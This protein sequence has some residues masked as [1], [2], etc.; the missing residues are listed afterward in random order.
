[1]A[2]V[3]LCHA[4]EDKNIVR[5]LAEELTKRGVDVWYDEY[6]L[7][8]GDSLISKI[9]DGLAKSR[10]GVVI[11]SKNFF[12]KAWPE[13]ELRGLATRE[14]SEGKKV[15]LPIWHG[16]TIQDILDVHP[17]LA[18]K[19]GIDTSKGLHALVDAILSTLGER[20]DVFVNLPEINLDIGR[21]PVTNY[22]Y[23]RFINDGGYHS[24]GRK[25]WWSKDGLEVWEKYISRKNHQY[26][27]E[28]Q[29][30]EDIPFEY[31]MYW[32][33]SRYNKRSQPVVGVSWFE[34]EAY[35]NWLSE[36]LLIKKSQNVHV[37]LP[38]EEEWRFAAIGNKDVIFPWGNAPPTNL[39][40]HL[41]YKQGK[42]STLGEY[43]AGVSQAGCHDLIGNVWEWV[44]DFSPESSEKN[45]PDLLS[46][47]KIMGGCVF[48]LPE[49]I[50]KIPLAYRRPGYR[51]AVIG[52]RTVRDFEK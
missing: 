38:T 35:C 5:P 6:S 31:P 9:D 13:R 44:H 41:G 39:C 37:R 43:T 51:H 49:T 2:D 16:I 50:K 22:E 27:W 1:M 28:G 14:L 12:G 20:L 21:F 19:V 18:D 48:D 7:E 15:I 11:L 8:L 33:N 30:R 40:A 47:A 29:R 52:F 32:D 36:Q 42:P 25:R 23:R 45:M 3:F 10:F 26:L 4:G 24:I 34:A 46:I 17:P